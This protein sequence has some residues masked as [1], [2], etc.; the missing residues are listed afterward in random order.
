MEYFKNS[1]PLL[2]HCSDGNCNDAGDCPTT[3]KCARRWFGPGCQQRSLPN[4][5]E[6]IMPVLFDNDDTTCLGK[7]INTMKLSFGHNH[8]FTWLRLVFGQTGQVNN[9]QISFP[10]EHGKCTRL[11]NVTV[12]VNAVDLSCPTMTTAVNNLKVSWT[13]KKALCSCYINGDPKG[14]QHLDGVV[15]SVYDKTGDTI[16]VSQMSTNSV[17]STVLLNPL[18]EKPITK[19]VV[20][21]SNE[22]IALRKG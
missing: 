6:G 2:C 16:P 4:S 18:L 19:I 3:N 20:T 14:Y 8:N 15:I 5:L 13:G 10:G 9:F 22:S 21:L 17:F 12:N 1:K 7:T 11:V